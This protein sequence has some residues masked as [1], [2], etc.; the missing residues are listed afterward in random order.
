MFYDPAELVAFIRFN[1]LLRRT[2][3]ELMH[4]DLIAI[5]AGLGELQSA[6]E[7]IV[8]CRRLGLSATEPLTTICAMADEW[9][10]TFQREYTERSVSQ[11]F[12]KLIGLSTNLEQAIKKELGQSSES[13]VQPTE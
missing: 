4:A 6:G 11:A 2:L 12:D 7:R 8:D 13:A 10:Q 1:F 5:R 9:K 3:I